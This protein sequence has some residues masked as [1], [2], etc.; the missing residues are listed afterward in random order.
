VIESIHARRRKWSWSSTSTSR[1]SFSPTESV[2][3]GDDSSLDV[4]LKPRNTDPIQLYIATTTNE[5]VEALNL[6]SAAV[7][8]QRNTATFNI[9]TH[10]FIICC[11]VLVTLLVVRNMYHSLEDVRKIA[12]AL[13]LFML[14]IVTLARTFGS[15]GYSSHAAHISHPSWLNGDEILIAR[16][17]KKCKQSRITALAALRA[18]LTV[19][20]I[21]TVTPTAGSELE[22]G[23]KVHD[24]VVG[25]LI[26]SWRP[27]EGKLTRKGKRVGRGLIRGWTVDPQHLHQHIGIDMLTYA[28]RLCRQRGN[29]HCGQGSNTPEGGNVFFAQDHA[30]SS[31]TLPLFWASWVTKREVWARRRLDDVVDEVGRESMRRG[32][33]EKRW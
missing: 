27:H 10:P 31:H 21:I 11:I 12:Q 33:G 19:L 22:A 17:R 26:L 8:A 2:D 9:L 14:T 28:A 15:W 30:F 29:H 4:C 1:S 25:V 24:H 32:S 23:D 3:G 5:R 6:L 18:I 20:T 16:V 13:L 7:L